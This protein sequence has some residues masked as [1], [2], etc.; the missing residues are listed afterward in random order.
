MHADEGFAGLDPLKKRFLVGNRQV[1]GG[2]CENHTVII[3]QRL[4]RHLLYDIVAR[5]SVRAAAGVIDC[6]NAALF[7]ES[8]EHFFRERN[9]TVTETLGRGDDEKFLLRSGSA[10]GQKEGGE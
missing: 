1:A 10:G 9:R 4:G 6:E 3:L 5:F 7:A 8:S 2:V